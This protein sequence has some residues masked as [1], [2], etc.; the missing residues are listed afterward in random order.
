MDKARKEEIA[1]YLK[2]V[3]EGDRDSLDLLYYAISPYIRFIALKYIQNPTEVSDLIQDF[4][5]EVPRLAR[6]YIYT[7]SAYNYLCKCMRNMALN[8]CKRLG[9]EKQ[10]YEEYVD[11]LDYR[12]EF[13]GYNSV[14]IEERNR[15]I[16]EAIKKLPERQRTVI[17][18]TYFEDKSVRKIASELHV[19]KAMIEKIKK[20]AIRNLKKEIL[21]FWVDKR[22]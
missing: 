17:M 12:N 19:S 3:K 22:D 4:W 6:S 7:R 13:S 21:A 14:E 18:L 15:C 16:D 2:G 5:A 11:F 8:R 10:K 9:L 20:S 1:R